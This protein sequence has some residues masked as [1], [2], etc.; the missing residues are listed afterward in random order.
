MKN[1]R[2]NVDDSMRSEYKRT[3]F[4]KMVRGKYTASQGEVAELVSLLLACIGEDEG[5]T[6][7]H[8]LP[9]DYLSRR[10]GDWTYELGDANQISLRYWFSEC[11]N[12]E[13][14]FS[15]AP[16]V[17][18]AQDRSNLQNLLLEHVRA[19]RNRVE[20]HTGTS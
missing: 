5:L 19:L 8:H 9:A 10:S 14:R 7:I 6:F 4:R 18:T 3:D 1:V 13:E 2:P 15:R 12:F 11:E 16:C 17:T 20:P